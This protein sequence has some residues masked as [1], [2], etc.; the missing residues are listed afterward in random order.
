MTTKKVDFTAA[1]AVLQNA[2]DGQLLAGVSAAVMFNGEVIDTFC[3]G[4]ADQESAE[5]LRPDHLHRAF[6]NTKIITSTLVMH[7]LD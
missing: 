2:I 3:A 1:H 6:S 4:K 7:L 5:S